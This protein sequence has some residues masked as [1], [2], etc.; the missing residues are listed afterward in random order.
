MSLAFKYIAFKL[1]LVPYWLRNIHTYSQ[2][3]MQQARN[4]DELIAFVRAADW[5]MFSVPDGL[6]FRSAKDN[7]GKKN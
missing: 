5:L 4:Q 7:L 3:Q 1:N 2:T 6:E